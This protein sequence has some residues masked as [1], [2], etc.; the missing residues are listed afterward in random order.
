MNKAVFLFGK[1]GSGKTY[2][3]EILRRRYEAR[4]LKAK[5]YVIA[6]P[7]YQIAR[8]LFGMV[9]KDRRL[10]QTIGDHLRAIDRMCFLNYLKKSWEKDGVD[11][12]IVEDVRLPEEVN[13]LKA[14]GFVGVLIDAPDEARARRCSQ[15]RG[16]PE[17]VNDKH[18]TESLVDT[19]IPD[20]VFDSSVDGMDWLEAQTTK[21][22][23][24]LDS[25]E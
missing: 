8:D 16:I 23:S 10:L 24:Y 7:I 3:A 1:K 15:L 17:D 19:L 20:Y 6:E 4:G 12:V 18:P 22:V 11:V 2:V 25:R 13:F 9:E 21:L 14:E 5:V